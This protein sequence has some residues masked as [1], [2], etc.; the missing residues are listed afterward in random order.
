MTKRR[1]LSEIKKSILEA[2]MYRSKFDDDI[3][4]PR[5]TEE[6]LF[7]VVTTAQIAPAGYSSERKLSVKE[8]GQVFNHDNFTVARI[9]EAI[10]QCPRLALGVLSSDKPHDKHLSQAVHL[11]KTGTID[12]NYGISRYVVNSARLTQAM[13][14]DLLGHDPANFAIVFLESS[15]HLEVITQALLVM[16]ERNGADEHLLTALDRKD[17]PKSVFSLIAEYVSDHLEDEFIRA[18]GAYFSNVLNWSKERSFLLTQQNIELGLNDNHVYGKKSPMN[19]MHNPHLTFELGLNLLNNLGARNTATREEIRPFAKLIESNDEKILQTIDVLREQGKSKSVVNFLEGFEHI[20]H[21]VFDYCLEHIHDNDIGAFLA[22]HPDISPDHLVQYAYDDYEV[23]VEVL[24]HP[25]IKTETFNS[26]FRAKARFNDEIK[27]SVIKDSKAFFLLQQFDKLDVFGLEYGHDIFDFKFVNSPK[28]FTQMLIG[29]KHP[30]EVAFLFNSLH[31]ETLTA[32]SALQSTY[33][34]A[35][36]KVDRQ[37]YLGALTTLNAL[38]EKDEKG[39][40]NMAGLAVDAITMKKALAFFSFEDV[41]QILMANKKDEARDI[42]RLTVSLIDRDDITENTKQEK[43]VRRWL[44]KQ[45]DFGTLFHDYLTNKQ[46]RDLG[47]STVLVDFFQSKISDEQLSEIER[48]LEQK[49]KLV[50]PVHAGELRKLGR[51]QRH[52]VGTKYYADRCVDGSNII[53]A[54]TTG[55]RSNECFTYQFA[56]STGKL[57]QAKGFSNSACE[58]HLEP[59]AKAVFAKILAFCEQAEKTEQEIDVAA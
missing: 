28:K 16:N 5:L 36:G 34:N 37:A 10:A 3:H 33:T 22:R 43:L 42:F 27:N 25:N 17:L 31:A 53:F 20:S 38:V 9:E 24:C 41:A 23:Q 18:R 50:L 56:R 32:I 55:E 51:A 11:L 48:G 2:G 40:T 8:V 30:E 59:I 19:A 47:E 52:C 7:E 39:K 54:L 57:E 4:D 46:M 6:F 49:I 1:A 35:R 44:D 21:T 26:L 58:P 14:L 45:Q 12:T 15:N 29:T 13:S